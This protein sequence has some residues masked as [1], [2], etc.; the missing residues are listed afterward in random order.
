MALS[1]QREF[2]KC[3]VKIFRDLIRVWFLENN[4]ERAIDGYVGDI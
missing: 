3:G 4:T 2:L 1:E